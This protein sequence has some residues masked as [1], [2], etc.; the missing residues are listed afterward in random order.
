MV[1]EMPDAPQKSE[2]GSFIPRTP[3]LGSRHETSFLV[4]S[5]LCSQ[6][7][8]H[9]S[10]PA[11]SPAILAPFEQKLLSAYLLISLFV[12]AAQALLMLIIVQQYRR[13]RRLSP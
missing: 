4:S 13:M 6:S 1:P 7:Q 10:P 9:P 5:I 12:L 8:S 2:K 11:R 3:L